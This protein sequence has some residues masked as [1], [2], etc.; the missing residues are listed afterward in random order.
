[1]EYFKA[2]YILEKKHNLIARLPKEMY[3]FNLQNSK[4]EQTD[5]D[6]VTHLK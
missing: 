1:M 5:D 3:D 4:L 6:I 2:R